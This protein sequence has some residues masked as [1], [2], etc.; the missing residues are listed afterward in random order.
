VKRILLLSLLV[1]LLLSLAIFTP[2]ARADA[3][4][5]RIVRLSLIQGE[6]RYAREFH[7]NSLTDPN[8]AWEA[9]QL[10]LPIR[11]GNA[12]STGN[13]RA[14][15][16]FENGA[17]AFL[18]ANTIL[19]FYDLSLNDGARITRLVL[20]QGSASFHDRAQG[21]DYFSVTGGDFSAAVDGRATFR[22]E[23]FDDG[24]TLNVSY[25]HVQVLQGDKSTALDKGQS[26]VLRVQD[27]GNPVIAR[28]ASSD[29]FDRWVSNRIQNEDVVNSQVAT[30]GNSSSYLA[31][32][33]DLYTYGSWLSVGGFNCW[34]PFGAGLGWSPFDYG[35][36]YYDQGGLG[37]S[38]LGTSPWGWLPYHYGGWIFSP[39]YGWVWNP[40][41]LLSG[42][43]Q[44]YHPVTAVF[45]R[46]GDSVGLVPMHPS[47]KSGKTP[48][49]LSQGVYP[50]QGGAIGKS[51]TVASGEKWSVQKNAQLA[52]FS[53]TVAKTSAPNRITSTM[54]A[55][56][57]PGR[58]LS[59]GHTS[60]IVYDA[61]ERRFVNSN[62]ANSRTLNS[63]HAA[64]VA[65]EIKSPG[66]NTPAVAASSN[67]PVA[68]VPHAAALPP[69]PSV[70]P[71]PARVAS[72]GSSGST[73]VGGRATSSS[74]TSSPSGSYSSAGSSS[75]PSSTGGGRPH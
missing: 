31:G 54:T 16:E 48:L 24:S 64:S 40:G 75:H 23:N 60:S 44:P 11:Q 10:N 21:L 51:M 73:W 74:G 66:K 38:F 61:S 35:N 57:M 1:G 12:L 62:M 4:H 70:T 26:F 17:M 36:W 52:G 6:V 27:P 59:L 49:N 69:R 29:D 41:G 39:S 2:A 68:I 28:A 37:W 53:S 50:I 22:L 18:G 9:A 71:A 20:R 25:G 30:N 7:D 15:V 47:D 34:R 56:S 58:E 45:V 42:R 63:G 32:Y 72:G 33:S 14:E 43:P 5:A 3:S 46:S 19:E 67:V 65:N 13:G 55:P 8:V